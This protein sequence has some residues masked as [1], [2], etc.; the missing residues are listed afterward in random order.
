MNIN[1][2]LTHPLKSTRLIFYYILANTLGR[3]LY[4]SSVFQGRHF[5]NMGDTRGNGYKWVCHGIFWQKI[6]G[7]NRH[8]PWP[9]SFRTTVGEQ[10][11]IH[12]HPDDLNN[13]M[14]SG[15][16]FQGLGAEIYIGRGTYIAPNVGIITQSHDLRD[17]SKREKAFPVN[18]GEK[19]WIGMNVIILPGV[20]LGSHTVV[21][22]GAIVTKSFTD[23]NCIIAGNPAKKIKMIDSTFKSHN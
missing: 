8:V 12:F 3:L 14:T 6:I 2:Y 18:I 16:Y 5:E 21:G 11:N 7:I 15:S 1:Y 10:S 20:T 22:A 19:C 9:T 4:P 17:P 13:F 23:G